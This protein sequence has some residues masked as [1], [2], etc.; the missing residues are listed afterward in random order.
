MEKSLTIYHLYPDLLDV[1]ADR[2]NVAVIEKRCAWRG[3]GTQVRT[4]RAGE[5]ADFTDADIVLLGTGSAVDQK[6]VSSYCDAL[7]QPLKAYVEDGGVLLAIGAGYQL[8]GNFFY[9]DGEKTDGFGVLDI[10]THA[11]EKRFIGHFAV[12]AKI[13]GQTVT[14]VGF[15]HHTGRTEIKNHTPLG[16][17]LSGFGN[18]EDGSEGV[19]YK[20]TVG[21]NMHGPI[22]PKNP[23][24]ADFLIRNAL[25]KKYGTATLSALDDSMAQAARAAVLGRLK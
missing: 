1:Y 14:L 20:N 12:E 13:G 10:D 17:V 9:A 8:L 22:L 18:A 6:K 25:M 7:A 3:I 19:L 11:S 4:L 21:T 2:G 15:E 16:R 24:L 5:A 23:E